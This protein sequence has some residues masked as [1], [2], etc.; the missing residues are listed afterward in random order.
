M[1]LG[2]LAVGSKEGV[3]HS[4]QLRVEDQGGSADRV[5]YSVGVSVVALG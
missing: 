4:P 5:A 2:S 3:L 1:P